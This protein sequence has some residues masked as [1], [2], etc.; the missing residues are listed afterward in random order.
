MA[1]KLPRGAVWGVPRGGAIVAGMLS[2]FG[3]DVVSAPSDA[4]LA[5]DDLID[6]GRTAAMVAE[7]YHLTV[8]P[9]VEKQPGEWIVFP[10]EGTAESDGEELVSR[11]IQMIG[12]DTARAGIAETPAR[13]VR[14]W[15][16]LY[17]G[18]Q[19]DVTGLLKW[20]PDNTDEMVVVRGIQFYSTC[21]HH[22]L[23]FYG[24]VDVGYVPNGAVLGV[25]KMA[26]L[27]DAYARRLQIQERLARQVGEAL[28]QADPAPL[29]VAVRIR[30]QH[31]CMMARG[32]KQQDAVMETNYLTGVFRTDAAARH[33]FLG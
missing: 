15:A 14:S 3:V 19:T 26:R 20:F 21:E 25:S 12:D 4:S 1:A 32:V 23:P 9:L 8:V 10:W 17:G 18:Y 28:A 24:T 22:L 30:G 2:R 27:V 11:M 13:V 33:E 29:G 16:E 7:K 6:S 31:L 5:V